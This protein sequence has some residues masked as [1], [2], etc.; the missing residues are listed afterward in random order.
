MRMNGFSDYVINDV[1]RKLDGVSGR[2]MF[3]GVGIYKN[4]V[5]FALIAYERLYMKVD[6]KLKKEYEA[7]GSEPFV[8]EGKGRLVTMSYWLL[9]D[10]A[11]EQPALAE[12]WAL[13]SLAV[14]EKLKSRK[15]NK[16]NKQSNKKK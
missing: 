11:L 14:A 2:S 8:Y 5:M 7:A 4:G 15:N 13:K 1:F 3:G 6:D 12:E 16:K 10:D 9:P